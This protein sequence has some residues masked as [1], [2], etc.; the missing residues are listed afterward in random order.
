M[1]LP[2]TT[3]IALRFRWS[4]VAL[5]VL[6]L[7]VQ[8]LASV[9][10]S[11][12]RQLRK[13]LGSVQQQIGQVRHQIRVK[14]QEKRTVIGQLNL[15]EQKLEVAQRNLS[16]NKLK[17]MDAESDL[18]ATVRRLE[19][20]KK[21]LKRRQGLLAR[22]IVDIYEGEDLDYVNVV[23]GASDMW[24]FLTQAHYLKKILDADAELI[25]QIKADK[26]A[27]ERD[28]ARQARRVEQI[29]GL[30][31]R[32]E[33]ER[34]QISELAERRRDQ[35]I[36]IEHSK[37]LYEKALDE[38]LA[39]SAEIEAEIRRIQCTPA[40]RVRYA[41][42]FRGALIRPCVGRLTSPFGYRRHPITGVYKLHT[43]VDFAACAG[44]PIRAAA[45]GVVIISGWN[46]AY[47]YAV[48]IDHG[49]GV[50]TLYGHCSSLLVSVGQH[51]RQGEIIA[52]VGS[53][54]LSTG[55]H[56]HFEKRI[57]GRPV[58]PL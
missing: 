28:K 41:R 2:R 5:L 44:T 47:G 3:Y 40:G 57:D 45:D 35:L 46:G 53:T 19:R 49:G 51:V 54:G 34:N 22:R 26:A 6:T 8:L 39:K 1:T 12:S 16:E 7:H 13:R 11:K 15:T 48:V 14:E 36:R 21:Q 32:L 24:T 17:L 29:Q 4:I 9:A 58:N 31:V 56:C 20:T 42:T 23:L 27:I 33:I 38:L 30:Q 52:R 37:E 50:S 18:A 43:G 10:T 25:S 55:P